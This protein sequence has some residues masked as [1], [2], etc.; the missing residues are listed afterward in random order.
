MCSNCALSEAVVRW[1][2]RPS[3]AT[4]DLM[5]ML[6][7]DWMD[8]STRGEIAVKTTGVLQQQQTVFGACSLTNYQSKNHSEGSARAGDKP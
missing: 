3:L 7:G 1:V 4:G 5:D 8:M 6:T 2:M